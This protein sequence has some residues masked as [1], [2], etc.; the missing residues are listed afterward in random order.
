[1]KTL[2]TEVMREMADDDVYITAGQ[3]KDT[4]QWHGIM[5]ANHPTPSGCERWMMLYSDKR[6][7]PDSKTAIDR[8][9][10]HGKFNGIK[11][12]YDSSTN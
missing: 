6:G 12:V 4:H 2:Q 10:E 1:M 11:T 8:F 9:V 7:W 3:H 5:M